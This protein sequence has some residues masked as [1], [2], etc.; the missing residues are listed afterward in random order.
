MN[1]CMNEHRGACFHKFFVLRV[2]RSKNLALPP[3]REPERWHSP[4]MTF[5][6]VDGLPSVRDVDGLRLHIDRLLRS[7]AK[8]KLSICLSF[9][10]SIFRYLFD[11]FITLSAKPTKLKLNLKHNRISSAYVVLDSC[12]ADCHGECSRCALM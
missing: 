2:Q 5:R 7:V 11:S 8:H 9:F 10:A 4:C 6:D 3:A 12:P 1:R